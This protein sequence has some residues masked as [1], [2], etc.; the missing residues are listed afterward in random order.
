MVRLNYIPRLATATQTWFMDANLIAIWSAVEPGLG[1][2][3]SSLATLRPLFRGLFR[4]GNTSLGSSF[5]N[6][7]NAGGAYLRFASLKS[8]AVVEEL[9]ARAKEGDASASGSPYDSFE[10][11]QGGLPAMRGTPVGPHQHI[12]KEPW[13][14]TAVAAPEKRVP[15][16]MGKAEEL[17]GEDLSTFSTARPVPAP[18]PRHL[19]QLGNSTSCEGG[20][21][22]PARSPDQPNILM[23]SNSQPNGHSRSNSN[24]LSRSNSKCKLTGLKK[25]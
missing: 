2:I 20:P 13:K 7:N 16:R 21:E 23:R 5:N 8:A 3:A 1:I 25:V 15:S 12:P 19:I 11:I 4:T 9:P 6:N 10:F 14:P 18:I 17:L 24:N 22:K